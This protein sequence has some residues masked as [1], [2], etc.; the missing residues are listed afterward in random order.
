MST[1]SC[2]AAYA[3]ALLHDGLGFG[4][5]DTGLLFTDTIVTPAGEVIGLDWTLGEPPTSRLPT[6]YLQLCLSITWHEPRAFTSARHS[7]VI[8]VCSCNLV[9]EYIDAGAIILAADARGASTSLDR[10]F[11]FSTARTEKTANATLGGRQP[12]LTFVELALIVLGLLIAIAFCFG[13]SRSSRVKAMHT[14]DVSDACNLRARG[15]NDRIAT[16]SGAIK[17]REMESGTSK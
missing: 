6:D 2:R 11:P 16:L 10:E 7:D 12:G 17:G 1:W 14:S 4:M 3:V 9:K 13:V 8:S 5:E 15:R